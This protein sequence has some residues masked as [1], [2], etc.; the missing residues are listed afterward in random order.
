M[1]QMIRTWTRYVIFAGVFTTAVN[2]VFL[3]VPL[4]MMVVHDKVLF[5]FSAPTLYTLGIGLL[6]S[7]VVMA[8]L[9]IMRNRIMVQAGIDLI[10][11]MTPQVVQSMQADAGSLTPQGYDRGL[12]DLDRLRDAVVQ[13]RFFR[14]L[15]LPW[16]LIFLGILYLIH[17]LVGLVAGAGAGM[18]VAF[19]FLLRL[20]EAKRYALADA[21]NGANQTFASRAMA[22]GEV[23]ASM[24]LARHLADLLQTRQDQV[25]AYTARADRFHAGIGA[26]IRFI[27]LAGVAGVFTAGTWA[28]FEDEITVGAMIASVMIAVRIWM[29][30][31]TGL[32]SMKACIDAKT[33]AR[34]LGQRVTPAPARSKTE[35][36]E[37]AGKIQAMGVSVSVPGR[38]LLNNISLDLAPG[39]ALG[40]V[41]PGGAGKSVLCRV[42]AGIWPPGAGEV[43][44]DGAKMD[45][46]PEQALARHIGY[47]P[48]EPQLLPG[49][50]ARNIARF[51]PKTKDTDDAVIQAATA[52]GV[53]DLILQLPGGYDTQI[54]ANGHPLSAG[55]RQLISLAR[56]LY[57]A[58]RLV[59][60]D[61]P[62]TFLD[63][64]GLKLLVQAMDFLKQEN[65]TLV[66]VTDRPGMLVKMDQL[67]VIKNG[68]AALYG[69]AKDVMAR[70]ADRTQPSQQTSG[71]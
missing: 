57:G 14:F 31:D 30:L 6:I 58:P 38:V 25:Q 28:F 69:P 45:Q 8:V 60:M 3:A 23:A 13:G 19:Q 68:Q 34:R 32:G 53:H 54:T 43:R 40:V 63:D 42:L 11:Q 67:L 20:L 35:L 50:V 7:L 5:S 27:H 16:V 26:V 56:A 55:R 49:T 2:L 37:P 36:P 44:L 46:W 33:S 9:E 17:P 64:A 66:M 18:A 39:Q 62:H 52:A 1:Q 71:E 4:Y 29:C 24:G 15:D 51:A 21:G 41:G 48:Q 12:A 59:V 61:T 65:T 10:Q 22:A 47:M 70:L